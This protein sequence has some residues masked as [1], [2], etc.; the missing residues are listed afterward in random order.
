MQT[1][2]TILAALIV[3]AA[4]GWL[5]WKITR[6]KDNLCDSCA[7]CNLPALDKFKRKQDRAG[8]GNPSHTPDNVS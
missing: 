1:L 6:K 4:A 3:L 5:I 2:Q 8:K 7:G